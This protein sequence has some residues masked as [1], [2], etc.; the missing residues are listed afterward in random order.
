[1]SEEQ[2]VREMQHCDTEILDIIK[3]LEQPVLGKL[4][5]QNYKLI[6]GICIGDSKH[7]LDH[8]CSGCCPNV[9]GKVWQ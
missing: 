9:C 5:S 1:M 4:V 2:Y 6:N 3:T 7:R 8:E